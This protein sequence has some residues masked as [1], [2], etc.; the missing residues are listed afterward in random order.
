MDIIQ[1]MATKVID[2]PLNLIHL[3]VKLANCAVLGSH[4]STAITVHVSSAV[5]TA[6]HVLE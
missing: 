4:C 1:Y 3:A 6:L 5:T 2:I